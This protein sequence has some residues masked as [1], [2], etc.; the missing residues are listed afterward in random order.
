MTTLYKIV[1]MF[2]DSD[3]NKTIKT[4]L[5]IEEAREH[6]RDS[7]TSSSTCKL[8][9]NI[10]ITESKGAWFDGFSEE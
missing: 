5:T 2:K 3:N 10:K 7:E 6:C 4:G 8:A 1:R 9:K